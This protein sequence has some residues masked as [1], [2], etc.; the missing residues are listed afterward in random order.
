MTFKEQMAGHLCKRLESLMPVDKPWCN[1]LG[2]GFVI[3]EDHMGTDLD[4][5]NAARKSFNDE[6]LEFTDKDGKLLKYLFENKH[7]SPFE[8]VEF[9]FTV[10]APIFVANQW[11]RHRTWSFNEVSRR[12]TSDD[13]DFWMPD[14]DSTFTNKRGVRKQSKSNKQSSVPIDVTKELDTNELKC[15][16][17]GWHHFM[18]A[19]EVAEDCYR[20]MIAMGMCREQARAV[21]P[22]GLMTDFVAKVDLHNLLHFLRLRLHPHA[23]VEIQDYAL[24]ILEMIEP[25]VPETI[26]LFRKSLDFEIEV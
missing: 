15:L 2:R 12:Y 6:S 26:K 10:R 13:I 25:I 17:V 1:I 20:K 18:S 24:A 19:Y 11:M 14:G 23:Q 7:T 5:I 9:K 16:M 4:I 21:L 3:L 8:M 22:V